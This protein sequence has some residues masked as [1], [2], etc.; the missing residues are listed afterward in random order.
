[1]GIFK[2]NI[3]HTD[4]MSNNCSRIALSQGIMVSDGVFSVASCNLKKKK[5]NL[6]HCI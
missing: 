6:V 2:R 5:K 1:M 3:K 4:E